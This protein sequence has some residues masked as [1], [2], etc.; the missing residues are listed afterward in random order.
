LCYQVGSKRDLLSWLQAGM[1]ESV[2]DV[3]TDP[4]SQQ[5]LNPPTRWLTPIEAGRQH[6]CVVQDE[7]IIWAQQLRQLV[8]A[9]VLIRVASP[10]DDE[11]TALV[12][13]NRRPLS[14]QLRR[15][16]KIEVREV[17]R[18]TSVLR[19]AARTEQTAQKTVD[20]A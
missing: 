2:P 5:D 8:E 14:D 6:A 13:R 18:V 20:E 17:H 16:L 4:P 11:Q 15:K 19:P 10:I 3:W 1:D 9:T 7:E 12:A